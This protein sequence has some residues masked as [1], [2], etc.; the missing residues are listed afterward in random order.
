METE[1]KGAVWRDGSRTS[2]SSELEK[3]REGDSLGRVGS[4]R[5]R[6][7]IPDPSCLPFAPTSDS[8][9]ERRET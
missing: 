2:V 8:G 4:F 6:E 5:K 1:N 7:V 3:S 9:E